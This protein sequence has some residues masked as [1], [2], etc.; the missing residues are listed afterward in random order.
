MPL[1]TWYGEDQRAFA[2]AIAAFA[3]THRQSW[4]THPGDDAAPVFPST[5]W[6]GLAEL[7]VLG[8]GRPDSGAGPVDVA[9][10]AEALGQHGCPGPLWHTIFA[11]A[12]LDSGS[13]AGVAAGE[14]IVSA[15]S[16]SLMPWPAQAQIF[17]DLTGMRTGEVWLCADAVVGDEVELLGREWWAPVRLR[18]E[19]R[20]AVPGRA[21]LLADLAHAGYLVGAA[22]QVLTATAE[23]VRAR[24]QFGRA[25]GD[26]QAVAFPLADCSSRLAAAGALVRRAAAAGEADD[27]GSDSPQWAAGGWA[28]AALASGARAAR[29]TVYQCHQAYGAIGFTE[30]G[31]LAWLG[32]RIATLATEAEAAWRRADDEALLGL[33]RR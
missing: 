21:V 6:R 27:D 15:G 12:L 11:S 33:A 8:L 13:A 18:R 17:L 2:D 10:A 31:P 22:G 9:A 1:E 16:P 29:Q 3:R 7:D 30:E 32:P 14:L 19:Q 20:L 26:F 24:H 5:A 4:Q 25:L 23:Y 28:Q